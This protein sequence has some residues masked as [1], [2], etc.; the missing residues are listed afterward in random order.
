M[1]IKIFTDGACSGNP[2]PGGA[3]F[4]A[5]VNGKQTY[6][7]SGGYRLTTNNRMEMAAVLTGLTFASDLVDKSSD[8]LNTVTIISD[9]QVVIATLIHGWK[10]KKNH[11][12]WNKI[13]TVVKHI[14]DKRTQLYFQKVDG[15][16][17]VKFNEQA[18]RLAVKAS[19]NTTLI[20]KVYEESIDKPK[21]ENIMMDLL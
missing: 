4:V 12:L 8:K 3:A 10:R 20:D 18:D 5:I 2:G 14:K 19:K 11:D 9:S 1:T 15:H 7:C 6:E 21:I 17:G 13:D 16:S